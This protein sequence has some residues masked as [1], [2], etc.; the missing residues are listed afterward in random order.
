MCYLIYLDL[1][2]IREMKKKTEQERK[3]GQ[4]HQMPFIWSI[5]TKSSVTDTNGLERERERVD[6]FP[7]STHTNFRDA[8]HLRFHTT[9]A[10][11]IAIM[12]YSFQITS[13]L[14]RCCKQN[15]FN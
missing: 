1:K 9:A 7:M 13:I 2:K 6:R 11:A 10:I 3:R 14:C 15:I 12:V 5:N 8:G 4:L